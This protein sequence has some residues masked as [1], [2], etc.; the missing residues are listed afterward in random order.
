[1]YQ[2]SATMCNL[3]PKEVGLLKST[4]KRSRLTRV[5]L[6]Y[7]L[8]HASWGRDFPQT[9]FFFPDKG[10]KWFQVICITTFIIT[11]YTIECLCFFPP[12]SS[13]IYV[14]GGRDFPASFPSRY[15][16]KRL[17]FA[18]APLFFHA[19]DCVCVNVSRKW[20]KVWCNVSLIPS[21]TITRDYARCLTFLKRR[22]VEIRW[23]TAV[24]WTN[25]SWRSYFVTTLSV[26]NS[27]R[28]SD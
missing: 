27:L 22:F 19:V 10:Y 24:N 15:A 14:W 26:Y 3:I 23:D 12:F 16:H 5:S 21:K 6:R 20:L 13:I 17:S 4:P 7:I 25:F 18:S 9:F 1:M 11:L 28:T 2:P 8:R